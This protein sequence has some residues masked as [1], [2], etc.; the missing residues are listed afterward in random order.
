MKT[1]QRDIVYK[2]SA[3][4]WDLY[5]NWYE[6]WVEE[7]SFHNQV[8]NEMQV[9]LKRSHSIL[10]IGGGSGVLALPMARKVKHV[11]VVEPS[12]NMVGNLT[13]KIKISGL[14]NINCLWQRWEDVDTDQLPLYDWAVM[15][16]SIYWTDSLQAFLD[17]AAAVCRVGLMV[18]ADG[19]GSN[20]PKSQIYSRFKGGTEKK[21]HLWH[22]LMDYARK[23]NYSMQTSL[24]NFSSRYSYHTLEEAVE[25]W[26]ILLNLEP[27]RVTELAGV[28]SGH[29]TCEGK[30]Y[31]FKEEN[32]AVVI[33]IGLNQGSG[34]S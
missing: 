1:E 18:V 7:N 2:G 27:E 33:Y 8:W 15:C 22:A 14:D 29:L 19:S 30:G 13:Q 3:E 11:T 25:H 26:S 34:F 24:L 10:D 20:H 17:K 9:H 12:S 16:N 4:F 21:P 28:L 32:Q 23:R 31:V 6:R 5:S